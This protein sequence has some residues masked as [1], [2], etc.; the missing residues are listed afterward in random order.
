MRTKLFAAVVIACAASGCV[1]KTARGPSPE[2]GKALAEQ[3]QAECRAQKFRTH[4]AAAR[5]LGEAEERY[6]KPSFPYPDL[7]SVRIATRNAIA[8]KVDAGKM[9]EAEGELAMAQ[10]NSKLASEFKGRI[11]SS[12]AVAAQSLAAVAAVDASR[13]KTCYG[14]P[15][16]ATCF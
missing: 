1:S 3:A 16:I 7:L 6:I 11:D 8:E 4:L 15:Q 2:E 13:P 10:A 14:G 5:C 12:Q 9:T